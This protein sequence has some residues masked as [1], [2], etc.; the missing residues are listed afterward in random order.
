MRKLIGTGLLIPCLLSGL[1]AQD[2]VQS[3][4]DGALDSMTGRTRNMSD[5]TNHMLALERE[6]VDLLV[7]LAERYG[8]RYEIPRDAHPGRTLSP[9]R[10]DARRATAEAGFAELKAKIATLRR[11]LK[12]KVAPADVKSTAEEVVVLMWALKGCCI[13]EAV[14]FGGTGTTETETAPGGEPNHILVNTLGR[15]ARHNMKVRL[16]LLE[17][18]VDSWADNAG[19]MAERRRQAELVG[20]NY[21]NA[22]N[23]LF[24][25]SD[26]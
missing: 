5:V 14:D 24:W 2:K 7:Q 23:P 21:P 13:L 11:A 18:A 25:G 12:E 3:S 9:F 26:D 10:G 22:S 19:G 6:V 15:L 4:V 8:I 20:L 16:G 17:D 1:L